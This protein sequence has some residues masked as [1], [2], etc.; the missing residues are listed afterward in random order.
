MPI[1]PREP[2]TPLA[3]VRYRKAT[4]RTQEQFA[5][6]F[7]HSLHAQRKYEQGQR[8]IPETLRNAISLEK[9]VKNLED[10]QDE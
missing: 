7:R 6:D 1:K 4:S 2:M 5:E 10:M 9:R 8:P 3:L